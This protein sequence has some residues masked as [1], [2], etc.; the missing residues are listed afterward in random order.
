MEKIKENKFLIILFIILVSISLIILYYDKVNDGDNYYETD[1][2]FLKHYEE[3]EYI[4]VSISYDQ[5]AR[6][7]LQDYVY[8]LLYEREEAYNLLDVDYRKTKFASYEDFNE[9]VEN[10]NSKK[11][12]EAK[13]VNYA[14][15]EKKGYRY[16]DVYDESNNLFIFKEKGVMQY[17][18]Y[19]DRYTIDIST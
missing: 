4:P 14:V 6:I 2:L 5:M 13:V 12:Q 3:N 10:L 15:T 8:K 11:F 16:F 18:V 19:F 9:Y 7:Y 1:N 17:T